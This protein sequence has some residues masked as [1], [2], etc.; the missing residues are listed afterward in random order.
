MLAEQTLLHS[1]ISFEIVGV[2][3]TFFQ[4]FE[5]LRLSIFA[6]FQRGDK[7]KITEEPENIG[8]LKPKKII[9]NAPR[10]PCVAHNF[11]RCVK[12]SDTRHI[13]CGETQ[14]I[15]LNFACQLSVTGVFTAE[16]YS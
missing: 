3:G 12:W 7:R 2:L 10:Q 11:N 14:I 8:E 5:L 4:R 16:T 1:H 15:G 6:L 9:R 13:L